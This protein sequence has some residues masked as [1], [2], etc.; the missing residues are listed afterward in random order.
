MEDN[1][2]GIEK[3]V[4]D[5]LFSL[6]TSHI[7]IKN[8]NER[9][10]LSYGNKMGLRINSSPEWGTIVIIRLPIVKASLEASHIQITKSDSGFKASSQASPDAVSPSS[11]VPER[12][13]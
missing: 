13:S 5:T 9:L 11:S 7:G 1:G 4:M 6:E 2:I 12:P 10:K 3:D 8:V